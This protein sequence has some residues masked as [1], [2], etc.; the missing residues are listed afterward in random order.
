MSRIVDA[1][2]LDN[3]RLHLRFEDGVEGTVD[4][5]E[6][7]GRGVFSA[8]SDPK[9]FVRVT[10]DPETRTVT[11]PGGIDLCPDRLYHDVAGAPLPGSQVRTS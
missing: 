4:L 5:S 11:W 1:R 2:A 3:Y 7:V 6:M 8:W 10:V 9:F